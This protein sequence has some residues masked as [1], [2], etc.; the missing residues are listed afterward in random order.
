MIKRSTT[1]RFDSR[2]DTW[3]A[4]L[5]IG[6]KPR[7]VAYDYIYIDTILNREI[8][9]GQAEILLAHGLP[10]EK[11][12]KWQTNSSVW[13]INDQLHTLF[14][15]TVSVEDIWGSAVEFYT[16]NLQPDEHKAKMKVIY[17]EFK[18]F[19]YHIN[20]SCGTT[21]TNDNCM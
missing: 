8:Y 5:A 2:N 16:I 21:E 6:I 3:N 10:V 9:Y 12:Y 14:D 19:G 7:Y 4:F 20:Y 11:R 1:F 15:Y 18:K 17:D 13:R